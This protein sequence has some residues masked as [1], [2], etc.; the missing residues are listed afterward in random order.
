MVLDLMEVV[1]V[2][3]PDG[4]TVCFNEA[5][6]YQ[7]QTAWAIGELNISDNYNALCSEAGC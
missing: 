4:K 7:V 6:P 3:T 2:V 5:L 1:A